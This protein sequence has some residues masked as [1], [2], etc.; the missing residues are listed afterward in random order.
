MILGLERPSLGS[1]RH[2][3][4]LD[5]LLVFNCTGPGTAMRWEV[6]SVF[7]IRGFI[8]FQ[9]PPLSTPIEGVNATLYLDQSTPS[10]ITSLKIQNVPNITVRCS[11]D[12]P[13]HDSKSLNSSSKQQYLLIKFLISL[14]VYNLFLIAMPPMAQNVVL[15]MLNSTSANISWTPMSGTFDLKQYHVNLCSD[16]VCV[17]HVTP[18]TFIELLIPA[19]TTVGPIF[20]NVSAESFCGDIGEAGS[21]NEEMFFGDNSGNYIV[22][23]LL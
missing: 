17:D 6:P 2:Y 14:R 11:T 12:L 22:N 15:K 16:T 1:E 5:D 19:D 7:N 4:C 9:T 21:S 13:A 18:K 3:Y 8:D 20:A 10:F 23:L